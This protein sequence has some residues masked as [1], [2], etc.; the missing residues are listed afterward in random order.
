MTKEWLR[1]L[2]SLVSSDGLPPDV[3]TPSNNAFSAASWRSCRSDVEVEDRLT[4]G[5]RLAGVVVDD[6]SN[7]LFLAVDVS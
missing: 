6:V 1:V 7:L 3:C 2:L 5:F 4:C